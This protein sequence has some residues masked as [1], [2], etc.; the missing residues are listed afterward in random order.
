MI[1]VIENKKSNHLISLKWKLI[2]K[3]YKRK[4]IKIL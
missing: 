4:K 3:V 2:L 1:K